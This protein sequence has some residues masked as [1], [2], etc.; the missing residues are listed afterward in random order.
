MLEY[1]AYV[2]DHRVSLQN[3]ESWVRV[4]SRAQ[5]FG[6]LKLKCCFSVHTNLVNMHCRCAYATKMDAWKFLSTKK[7]LLPGSK[8]RLKI[9]ILIYKYI[10]KYCKI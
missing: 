3:R 6:L 4:P 9:F 10:F 7:C 5:D 2:G 1:T 8:I